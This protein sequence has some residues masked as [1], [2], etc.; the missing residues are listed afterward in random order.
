MQEGQIVHQFEVND[1]SITFRYPRWSDLDAFIKMHQ[2]LAEEKVMARRLKLN[3]DTGGRMLAEALIGLQENRASYLLVEQASDLVGEGFLTRG[4]HGYFTVGLALL[5][6]ARGLGIGTQL[7][8]TLE[9]EACRL[10]AKRLYLTVWSANLVAIHVY[11]KVGYQECGRR[12]DWIQMDSG[13]ACDLIEMVKNPID[14]NLS[15]S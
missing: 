3:R 9:R 4:G 7:M 14:A 5:E 2:T 15:I 11:Q 12:P 10:G 6:R 8:N 13:E 1:G